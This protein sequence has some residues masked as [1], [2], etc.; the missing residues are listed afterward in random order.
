MHTIT[1]CLV[2]SSVASFGEAA[3]LIKF[4]SW[5]VDLSVKALADTAPLHRLSDSFRPHNSFTCTACK[6]DSYGSYSF[7]W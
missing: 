3:S 4:K 6:T 7:T 5:D 1:L 2:C